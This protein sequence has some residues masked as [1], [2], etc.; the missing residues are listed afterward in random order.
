MLFS[1]IL[2]NIYIGGMFEKG[3]GGGGRGGE[4]SKVS[5][6]FEVSEINRRKDISLIARFIEFINLMGVC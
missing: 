5:K 1:I 4:T 3:R 6:T 2:K